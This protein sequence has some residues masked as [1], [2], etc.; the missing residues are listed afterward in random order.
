VAAFS[1]GFAAQAAAG[2]PVAFKASYSGS[3]TLALFSFDGN[4]AGIFTYGEM[5]TFGQAMG[6]DV[7]ETAPD[8]KTCTVPGHTANAGTESMRVGD[9]DI[10]RYTS[11]GDLQYRKATSQTS[12]ADTSSGTPPF[13]FVDQGSGIIIGGTGRFAG[14]SGNYTFS[15]RGTILSQ[16]NAPGFGFFA[17]GSGTVSG[18]VNL[19]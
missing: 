18:V 6:Q 15:D 11:T 9:S 2:T 1:I 14:A 4:L 12:C 7:E 3:D 8:G 13:P 19:Q 16:P 5:G 10:V 17:G